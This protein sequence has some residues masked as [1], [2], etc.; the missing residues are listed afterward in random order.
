MQEGGF[1]TITF[2]TSSLNPGS[3]G[4]VVIDGLICSTV[5]TFPVLPVLHDIVETRLVHRGAALT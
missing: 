4:A 3:A 2:T 1:F 5:L